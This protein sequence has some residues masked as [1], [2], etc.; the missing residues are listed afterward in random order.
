[1]SNNP[2]PEPQ[3]APE[4]PAAVPSFNNSYIIT[5]RR[6]P[7]TYL[8]D[9]RTDVVP[10]PPGELYF[11]TA[12]GPYDPSHEDY[13]NVTKNPGGFL[14]ALKADLSQTVDANG[15]ANLAV[16]VHGL[17]NAYDD[18]IAATA[19]FGTALAT[20][21]NY[22]GL[23]IGFSWPSYGE[24]VAGLSSYYATGLPPQF[25]SGTIRD[26]INGSVDS[27]GAMIHM[28]L[29][30]NTTNR[31]LNLSLL[32]HSEGNFML[33]WGML[34]LQ[35]TGFTGSIANAVMMAADISGGMLQ[36][37]Q[38][39]QAIS[40]YCKNVNVYYSGCDDVL[41]YSNY[42]FV[43]F[44]NQLYPTRLGLIGPYAYPQARPVPKNVSGID[45]S[46]VTVDLGLI[47]NV[48]SCYMSVS[49]IV[50]DISSTLRSA[51]NPG[52]VLYPGSPNPS[53][54][55]KPSVNHTAACAPRP[56]LSRRGKPRLPGGT[57]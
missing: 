9:S 57:M 14:S 31:P 24:L 32:T 19:D 12:T 38:Y 13:S 55:L 46:Q 17:G 56:S 40:R 16:Y 6:Y 39:G 20:L 53:Y 50:A 11:S 45:C 51:N 28:L 23:V 5:N 47:S 29:S 35:Q 43:A 10:L 49:E 1:M 52:R 4:A 3:T 25:T 33:M 41:G 30:L 21:G 15:H 44:H 2:E 22:R 18:A 27:F 37:G 36:Q 48:H 54:Y 7:Y 26:N 34:A 42:N 8:T